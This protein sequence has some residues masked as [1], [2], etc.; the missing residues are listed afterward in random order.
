MIDKSDVRRCVIEAEIQYLE[1]LGSDPNLL[2]ISSNL[3]GYE[4]VLKLIASGHKGIPVYEL[5]TGIKSRFVSQAGLISRLRTMRDRGLLVDAQGEKRSQVVLHPSDD[6][7]E[8]IFDVLATRAELA[9]S[10]ESNRV[11]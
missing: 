7:R 3:G 10:F 6:V 8:R 11:P 1:S 5:V 2:F 9:R 4:A